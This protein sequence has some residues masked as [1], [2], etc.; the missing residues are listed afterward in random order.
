MIMQDGKNDRLVCLECDYVAEFDRDTL[1]KTVMVKGDDGAL[2]S[3]ATGMVV[4]NV[5]YKEAEEPNIFEQ[6]WSA[7]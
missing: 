1:V 6:W 4:P 3:Y 5:E 7:E 2:H